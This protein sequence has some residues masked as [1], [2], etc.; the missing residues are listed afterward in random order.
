LAKGEQKAALCPVIVFTYGW[1]PMAQR[2]P[3]DVRSVF[4]VERIPWDINGIKMFRREVG[5]DFVVIARG[6]S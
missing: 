4:D 6:G 5:E 2:E 3:T 1:D